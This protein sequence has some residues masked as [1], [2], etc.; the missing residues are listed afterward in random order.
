ML[1][2][3]T[4]DNGNS[5]EIFTLKYLKYCC[6]IFNDLILIDMKRVHTYSKITSEMRLF[7][8][9]W[10]GNKSTGENTEYVRC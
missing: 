9:F 2:L 5:F 3:Y 4:R 8:S 7:P 1:L 10:L 6:D